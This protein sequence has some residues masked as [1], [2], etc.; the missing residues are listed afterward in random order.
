M[1]PLTW[2]NVDA[3]DLRGSMAGFQAFSQMLGQATG[4]LN[5]SLG[6]FRTTQMQAADAAALAS[7]L[8]YQDSASLGQALASGQIMPNPGMMTAQG[9]AAI[10]GLRPQLAQTE[11]VIANTATERMRPDLLA[12]QT[13]GARAQTGLTNAQA[14]TES[15]RPAQVD[16][17]TGLIRAQTDQVGVNTDGARI[18]N[19]RAGWQ[20]GVDVRND[21]EGRRVSSIVAD[22][23]AQSGNSPEGA[24][25]AISRMD[26]PPELREAAMANVNRYLPGTFGSGGGAPVSGTPAGVAIGGAAASP[27]V[28]TGPATGAPAGV[29]YAPNLAGLPAETR[30]YAPAIMS[31]AGQVSGTNEEKVQQLWAALEQRESGGRQSAV[32]PRGARGVAQL[33]PETARELERRLGMKP[34]ETDTNADSNRRAGQAYL[35]QQL[36][37]FGGDPTL[38]LAAYNAGPGRV[39]EWLKN[40]ENAPERQ[41]A[42]NATMLAARASQNT[43]LTSAA[44]DAARFQGSNKTPRQVAQE[45]VAAGGGLAGTNEAWVTNQIDLITKSRR[46]SGAGTIN[47]EQA[48]AILARNLT[49]QADTGVLSLPGRAFRAAGRFAG[50]TNATPN[51][52]NGYRLNDDAVNVEIDLYRRGF[53]VNTQIGQ[54]QLA[55]TAQSLQAASAQVN[56]LATEVNRLRREAEMNPVV[57][58]YLNRKIQELATARASLRALNEQVTAD[59][60]MRDF[61]PGQRQAS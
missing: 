16:A 54:Q 38:A 46:E 59:P 32:S 53:P 23:L 30:A 1:A 48:G 55:A 28:S 36:N 61:R 25:F 60:T 12:A 9:L 34:F 26:I 8:R 41:A 52:G 6:N 22:A 35:L 57:V 10:A 13:E 33:K 11:N 2:R 7:A 14:V 47:A 39:R 42:E 20:L 49:N 21:Q 29:S 31:A 24:R 17:Q 37:N 5:E 43:S 51:L 15:R 18:G 50:L 44:A 56:A 19:Q 27:G 45:L 4:G 40:Q 3:P 58:P